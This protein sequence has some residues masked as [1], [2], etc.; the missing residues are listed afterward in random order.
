MKL[1]FIG[2]SGHF[3]LS[4]L[5]DRPDVQCAACGGADAKARF[6][7][8]GV[9]WFDDPSDMFDSFKPNVVN[10][11]A[12]PAHNSD[13]VIAALERNIP[14]VTDKPVAANWSQLDRITA[15]CDADAKRVVITEFPLRCHRAFAA[16]HRAVQADEIGQVLLATGQKSYRFGDARPAWYGRREQYGGSILFAASHAIDF[17]H[18]VTGLDF[19]DVR[20]QH[21]NLSK[22]DYPDFEEVTAT[23]LTFTTGATALVHSDYNRPAKAPT[24]GDD[25]LRVVGSKGVIEVRDER[26]VLMTHDRPPHDISDTVTPPAPHDAMLAAALGEP[27]D[28]FSTALSLKLA[29]I[30][31]HA[32]DAADSGETI[33]ITP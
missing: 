24:H 19:I 12:I 10:I 31:L 14:A 18:Y 21:A 23:M 6:A 29:S 32:R 13:W 7:D 2:G 30:L 15:L 16:A 17:I 25:R 26:C 27:S 9:P 33:E 20:G 1:G 11:G 22:P 28:L 3:Y 4:A 5:S 8:R